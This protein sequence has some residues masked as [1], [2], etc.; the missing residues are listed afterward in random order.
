MKKFVADFETVVFE[1]Q[2]RTD[3]WASAIV[4]LLPYAMAP[5]YVKIWNNIESTFYYLASQRDNIIVYY[6][7][8]RFDGS[9]WLSFFNDK[10]IKQ[11]FEN[12]PYPHFLDDDEM[13]NDTYKYL[14]SDVGI[15]YNIVY[16]TKTGKYI[17][18]LDSLKLIPLSVK[19]I[20]KAFQTAH[21]KTEI[22]YTGFRY[23]GGVIT[24]DEKSYIA[25]DV[26]VVAEALLQF[27]AEGHNKT[28]IGGCC[29]AEW[30]STQDSNDLKAK[31]P[32]LVGVPF[33]GKGF[34]DFDDF[35]RASYRGGWCYLVE[36]KANK[37]FKN[38]LTLDVNSL[39]PSM[40]HSS[41]GNMYPVGRPRYFTG[42]P[43]AQ[44]LDRTQFYYFVHIRCKFYI[45]DGFLPFIQIK[46]SEFYDPRK[47]L[48]SSDVELNGKKYQK[49]RDENGEIK[50][51][52]A[53]MVMTCTDFELFQKHYNVVELEIIESA[54]FHAEIGIF[55]VYIDKYYAVKQNAKGGKRT[56]AKLFLNNLYGK[57]ATSSRSSFKVAFFD[58]GLHFY[59]VKEH[60]KEPGYI[61][62]G[63]A[64]TS[65]ARCF[66]I[67]AAQANFHGVDAQGFIYADTDS[68][69]ADLSPEMVKNVT[70]HDKNMSCWKLEQ[71]W[72]NGWFVRPK[73]YIEDDGEKWNIA[74]AGM[75]KHAK[76]IFIAC[77][78]K[79]TE[80]D[81]TESE[82]K[83][84]SENRFT[85]ENFTIGLKIPGKLI[86]KQIAGGTVLFDT[87]FEMR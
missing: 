72:L 77:C 87:S 8:L 79:S 74:C 5:E 35:I 46:H 61:P 19:E 4:P 73:T 3:V 16:K 58:N 33:Y 22:E 85:M 69:H 21:Q 42:L 15:W 11:A 60:A 59:D 67:N 32:P 18:F 12:S 48:K 13:P 17:K 71:K 41:S 36:E 23:P 82:L 51:V 6:H 40:M 56:I 54:V 28:T 30:Q 1:G 66:T 70:I 57:M 10:G 26:L 43:P 45:K 81:F 78:G 20:G 34:C 68:V 53:D 29:L 62:I 83:F 14:I 52:K 86:A 80:E 84:I 76:E 24:D 2:E 44:F 49:Y 27:F 37:L 50:D 75:P 64:I 38:G 9:F 65:Y 63:S 25:N 31:F 7:N 47:M 39:Y 55:D